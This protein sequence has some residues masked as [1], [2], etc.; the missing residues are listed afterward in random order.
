MQDTEI[1]QIQGYSDLKSTFSQFAM[2]CEEQLSEENNLIISF[3]TVRDITIDLAVFG[4]PLEIS[5]SMA[6]DHQDTALGKLHFTRIPYNEKRQTVLTLYFN[7]YGFIRYSLDGPPSLYSIL[8]K[9]SIQMIFVQL[10]V[11]Y[12]RKNQLAYIDNL[13][14]DPGMR[15]DGFLTE[16]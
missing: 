11:T 2:L 8:D 1:C 5:Y 13:E 6:A 9:D 16:H 14:I 4:Q 3:E 10:L 7:K 12:V 15:D